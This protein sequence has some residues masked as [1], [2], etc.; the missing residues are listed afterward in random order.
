LRQASSLTIG[1]ITFLFTDIEGSTRGWLRNG[2]AMAA[3]LARHDALVE[4]QVAKHSGRVVRPRGE[5][6]SRFAVFARASDAV[7][8][9]GAIQLA[10]AAEPW[11]AG[12]D[13][14]VRIAVHSGEADLR[15]GD[16]YGPAVNHCARLRAVGHGG[17]VLISS[18]TADLVREAL[19][20]VLGLR[21][22]GVHQLKDIEKPEH[23][24]QLIHPQLPSDFPP[25][26]TRR[27]GR[28]KLRRVSSSVGREQAIVQPQLFVGRQA[29]LQRLQAAL[30][31]AAR[32][33]GALV[34]LSGEPGIGKTALCEQVVS[35]VDARRGVALV[36]HC[37]PEGSSPYQP[38]VEAFES[39]ALQRDPETLHWE[40][41]SSASEIARM[42]PSLR[43]LLHVELT[44]PEAPEDN[45]R[46]LFS[47]VLECL[48]N[49]ASA[50]PLLL[51]LEDLHDADRGTVDLLLYL[52]RHLAGAPLLVVCTYRD[53][54][55]D[56]AH[57]LAGALA[58]LR[59]VSQFERLHLGELSVN[60]VQRILASSSQRAVPHQWAEF[61]H[62]RSGGNAL[63]VHELVRYLHSEGA[64][65]QRDGRLRRLDEATLAGQIPEALRDVVGKRLS[66]LS[67]TA[68]QVLGVS[69]V[70]GR[71]FSL[72]VLRRAYARP[73]DE[74]EDAL[75]EAVG[76]AMVEERS[77][78]AGTITYGFRHAFIQQTLYDEILAPRRMRLHQQVARSLEDVHARRLE[79][80]AAELA[81]HYALSL[82]SSDLAKAVP[83]GEMAA[84]RA[85]EVFA[86]GEAARQLERAVTVQD[87]VNPD[88]VA[89]RCDLLLALGEALFAAGEADRV[90]ASVA[91]EALALADVVGDRGRAFRAIHI[92]VD[93]LYAQGA[94]FNAAQPEYL[95]WAE[96]ATQ[97]AE[98]DSIERVHADLVLAQVR[99]S[100]GQIAQAR[101]LR[102]EALALA[103]Q[104]ADSE[105]L[106]RSA[107]A[108][109][110]SG[111]P[112]HW[113][114]R[115]RLADECAGWPR[116][117]VRRQTL[118]QALWYCG[119]VQLAQGERDRAEELWRQ[120]EE[121]AE[122]TQVVT[123]KHHVALRN[124]ILAIIDGRLDEALTL[125]RRSVEL[126]GEFGVPVRGRQIGLQILHVPALYL[127]RADLWLTALEDNR[128]SADLANPGR[129]TGW[130]IALTAEYAMC[131]AQLGR[132]EEARTRVAPLLDDIEGR[133]DDELVTG[134]LVRLLEVAIILEH[135]TAAR[136]VAARLACVAHV[137]AE[138]NIY[139]C[140]ARHLG[141]AA[142]LAGD[143]ASARA[144]YT[145]AL[146]V[147][148][149]IR[150]RPEI[151]LVHLSLAA[152]LLEDADQTVRAEALDHL[153]L[154]IPELRDM[155][156][157]PALERGLGLLGCNP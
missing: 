107:T 29:E 103:R 73:D 96:R 94:G 118:A 104:H 4:G 9:A 3:A 102:L 126:A 33:Y 74:L 132:L 59:R 77:A 6:D 17:Q 18:V 13:L 134:Q 140:V 53:S 54:E 1:T 71:E 90:I 43:N 49:I 16:Y 69:S 30:E 68:N 146:E 150:L 93:A 8:A 85:T 46:R 70:I 99:F 45:R 123:V 51:V 82:D 88:D 100:R 133:L 48:R 14:R 137:T 11:P 42:A 125:I 155:H 19:A 10:L 7:S 129:P 112:R 40:F 23:I 144:Y 153:D 58:E 91:P 130:Y 101:S 81:D 142:K 50:H 72:E 78:R 65:E 24:W 34:M 119:M 89:K 136:A 27:P 83:Y 148:S 57:P 47:G 36:G 109:V 60:E 39:F 124:A 131:L 117:G 92:A 35:F 52:A 38:L 113:D 105:A 66:R 25:L 135:R 139:T 62:H 26:T 86:Y 55:V 143:R 114:E 61:V 128:E 76:A 151:A 106:F 121:L 2:R 37:Y 5:G 41:G 138:S 156:M 67:A 147:S 64:F 21:D 154:A 84:G 116:Q 141:D 95:T 115:V 98:P 87:L 145:E 149:K 12:A 32:G 111:A 157:Q 80:H 97:Y 127:G 75:E 20:P 22:L 44:A 63:F 28:S 122:Q 56:R 15:L 108:L 120:M 152:L 31:R 79:E 110:Y